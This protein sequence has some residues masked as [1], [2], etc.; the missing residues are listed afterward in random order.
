MSDIGPSTENKKSR[1]SDLRGSH[2]L[3]ADSL[4]PHLTRSCL[5]L[6]SHHPN[7]FRSLPVSWASVLVSHSILYSHASSHTLGIFSQKGVLMHLTSVFWVFCPLITCQGL[8][9]SILS[10]C[11]RVLRRQKTRH[12]ASAPVS[13][14]RTW[15]GDSISR[16]HRKTRHK[17]LVVSTA[18]KWTCVGIKGV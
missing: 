12:G 13:Y 9:I 18:R 15:V 2:H 6:L 5:F 10:A 11:I 17:C 1:Q 7:S 4:V 16:Y 3:I 8:S 14:T